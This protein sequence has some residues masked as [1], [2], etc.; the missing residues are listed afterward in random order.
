M[1]RDVEIDAERLGVDSHDIARM[2]KSRARQRILFAVVG[3]LAVVLSF[4]AGA[5]TRNLLP[6]SLVGYPYAIGASIPVSGIVVASSTSNRRFVAF[7]ITLLGVVSF[8]LGVLLTEGE[9]QAVEPS[10][11]VAPEYG[12]YHS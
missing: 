8:T 2:R 7:V 1:N 3:A 10:L 11:G 5:I 6:R 4:V 12:V 9:I